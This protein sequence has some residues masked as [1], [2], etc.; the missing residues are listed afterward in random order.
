M[1]GGPAVVADPHGRNR[2]GGPGKD[3]GLPFVARRP[4]AETRVATAAAEREREESRG[5]Q[6]GCDTA[7]PAGC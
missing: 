4:R 7:I 3:A 5:E 1:S 6:R 2:S